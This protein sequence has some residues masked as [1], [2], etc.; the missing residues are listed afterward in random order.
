MVIRA[1]YLVVWNWNLP[2]REYQG[3]FVSLLARFGVTRRL[4]NS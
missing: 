4:M 2:V 1:P 3:W